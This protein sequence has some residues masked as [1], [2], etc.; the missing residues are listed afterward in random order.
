MGFVIYDDFLSAYDGKSVYVPRP[1]QK[2][3]GETCRQ[4][5]RVG[6]SIRFSTILD[7][8]QFLGCQMGGQ[9]LLQDSTEPP[10]LKMEHNHMGIVPA[11]PNTLRVS[12]PV[13]TILAKSTRSGMLEKRIWSVD[14]LNYYPN[15]LIPLIKAGKLHGD[16]K[17]IVDAS[18]LPNMEKF[19]GFEIGKRPFLTLGGGLE[20]GVPQKHKWLH[21]VLWI[22]VAVVLGLAIVMLWCKLGRGGN[23]GR[24]GW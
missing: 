23:R 14:P 7:L 13:N 10:M 11:L 8:R 17:P 20:T 21:L 24:D 15:R 19:W 16:L 5:C 2:S 6:S 9:G 1:G 12:I 22:L 18:R 3:E 4:G